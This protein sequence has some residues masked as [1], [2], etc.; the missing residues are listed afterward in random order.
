[1]SHP[2]YPKSR[3]DTI[4]GYALL[5]MLISVFAISVSGL[6]TIADY[7]FAHNRGELLIHLTILLTATVLF[8]ISSIVTYLALRD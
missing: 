5:T 1:M 6:M 4:G 7:F 2:R 8:I 3:K